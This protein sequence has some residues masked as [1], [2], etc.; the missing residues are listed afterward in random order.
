MKKVLL[1][2]FMFLIGCSGDTE[3]FGNE[4]LNECPVPIE[5]QI[6]EY[7]FNGNG[8]DSSTNNLNT[9]IIE[10]TFDNDRFGS[11]NSSLNFDTSDNP[12]WGEIDDISITQYNSVMD[13]DNLTLYAWVNIKD[14]SGEY[15]GRPSTI[16]ARWDGSTNNSIFRFQVLGNGELFL[17]VSDDI[18]YTTDDSIS[19]NEWNHVAVSFNNGNVK[20]YF[21]GGLVQEISKDT[22]LNQGESHLTIGEVWMANG[23]WHY[24]NGNLDDVGM[25]NKALTACEIETLY[26]R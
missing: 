17:Q 25:F 9:E 18:S 19:F 13:V 21:N 2:I 10:A 22:S 4:I 23:Y 15:K 7:K 6:V 24:F 8:S 1:L 5:N 26:N 11:S 12:S 3:D 20:F 16:M 14:K